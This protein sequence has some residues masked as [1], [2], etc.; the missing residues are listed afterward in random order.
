M[1]Q[2]DEIKIFKEICL[3]DYREW[4]KL[5]LLGM[6][7]EIGLEKMSIDNFE[8]KINNLI[9]LI[10]NGEIKPRIE[11]TVAGSPKKW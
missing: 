5:G 10:E 2:E 1:T 11:G 6:K 7:D 8:L 4:V 9:K 3:K